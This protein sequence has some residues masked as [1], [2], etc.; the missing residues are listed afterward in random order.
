MASNASAH[1]DDGIRMRLHDLHFSTDGL[2]SLL[3]QIAVLAA[4]TVGADTGGGITVIREDMHAPT[5]A[6]GTTTHGPPTSTGCGH[7]CPC[8][9]SS[10][11]MRLA[12]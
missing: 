5:R 12:R 2:D 10:V 11:T 1:T 9:W 4:D 3:E 6:G 8:P 7:P